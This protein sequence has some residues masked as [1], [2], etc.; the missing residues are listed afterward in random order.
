MQL[1]RFYKNIFTMA[2]TPFL[3]NGFHIGVK[4]KTP[5]IISMTYLWPFS[6]TMSKKW[7]L[8]EGCVWS[9]DVEFAHQDT[10]AHQW[11]DKK[12]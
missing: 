12:R 10:F 6:N 8:S 11:M 2:T 7:N 1:Q 4:I 9:W 5:F 3:L